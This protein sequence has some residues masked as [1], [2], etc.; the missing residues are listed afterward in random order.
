MQLSVSRSLCGSGSTLT[1]ACAF[2]LAVLEAADAQ[3]NMDRQITKNSPKKAVFRLTETMLTAVAVC[4]RWVVSI[5]AVTCDSPTKSGAFTKQM[6]AC[7]CSRCFKFV[8]TALPLFIFNASDLC[9]ASFA[10]QV[11]AFR[12]NFLPAFVSSHHHQP[13]LIYW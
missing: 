5:D 7:A 12:K 8:V 13:H 6:V 1:F 3:S 10:V 2:K 9:T 4:Q 11:I